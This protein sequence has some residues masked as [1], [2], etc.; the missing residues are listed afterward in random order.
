MEKSKHTLPLAVIIS[1][2]SNEIGKAITDI[3]KRYG[4]PPSLLDV[5]L[6]NIQNQIKEMKAS[7]FSNNVSDAYEI[8]QDMEQSEKDS[9][10]SA[11]Q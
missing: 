2:A 6:L 10:E 1:I 4:L 9:E 3:G 5:A 7:E 11:Q 8:I